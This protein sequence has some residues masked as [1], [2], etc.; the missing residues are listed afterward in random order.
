MT[1]LPMTVPAPDKDPDHDLKEI[2]RT[3]A[4]AILIAVVIRTF[5]FEP[6]NIPSSS[7]EPTLLV[8][9]FLFVSKFGYGYS[10]LGTFWGLAPF[11]GR[12]MEEHKP[13]R[14]DVVVFKWPQDNSTDY[15]KRVIGLP[16]DTVQVKEGELYIN[17]KAV[18]R[19]ALA[20]PL[21]DPAG[22]PLLYVTDYTERLPDGPE[23]IIRHMDRRPNLEDTPLFTVPPHHYFMMGDNRDNSRDSRDPTGGVGY[24]PEE[25]IVG[26]AKVIFF[27][28]GNGD[29]FWEIWKWPFDVRWDRLFRV[30]G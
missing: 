21:Q 8:G 7:M 29:A 3:F 10:G 22:P 2:A 28:L 13:Q 16:G 4:W 19:A 26:K 15:I 9:D 30:I 5:L 25:N 18:P 6:F 20:T 23:H 14:G 24:V 11:T 12:I 1:E 27:S 17:G